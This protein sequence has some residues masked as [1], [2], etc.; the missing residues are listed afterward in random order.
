MKS[1]LMSVPATHRA[2]VLA[3]CSALETDDRLG[4]HW[5]VMRLK[6]SFQV[7][8]FAECFRTFWTDVFLCGMSNLVLVEPR[9]R[10]EYFVTSIARVAHTLD[11]MV[12]ALMIVSPLHGSVRLTTDPAISTVLGVGMR[13]PNVCIQLRL[14]VESGIALVAFK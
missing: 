7:Y 6:V 2:E 13:F 12:V 11:R 1:F 4:D 9:H 14:H 3:A 10:I 5:S 8:C